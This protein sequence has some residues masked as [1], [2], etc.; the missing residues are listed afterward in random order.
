VTLA[1][2][3][4][5]LSD[6]YTYIKSLYHSGDDE[7]AGGVEAI[8]NSLFIRLTWLGQNPVP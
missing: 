8:Y 5:Q 7:I 3:I 4:Q 1:E 6:E 2:G